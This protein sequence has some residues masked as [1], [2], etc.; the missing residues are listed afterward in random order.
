MRYFPKAPANP[1]KKTLAPTVND[2]HGCFTA[3]SAMKQIGGKV[4]SMWVDPKELGSPKVL[5]RHLSLEPLC[6]MVARDGSIPIGPYE[7]G[8][9]SF[10]L[11]YNI[12]S[13]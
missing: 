12:I 6:A 11:G 3:T 8:K 2:S 7:W 9:G 13:V 5:K 4:A 1:G 10:R